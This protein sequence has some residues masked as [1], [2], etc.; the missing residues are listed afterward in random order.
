[1]PTPPTTPSPRRDLASPD[2]LAATAQVFQALAHPARLLMVQAL[3]EGE[4]CVGDLRQLVGSDISTVSRHLSV[5]KQ[6][7]IVG[8]EKRG[9]QVFYSLL[10]PCVVDMFGCIE[11]V[12]AA[13][14]ARLPQELA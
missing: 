2:H 3:R 4:C 13:R 14:A 12:L 6:A 1:M 10:V 9:N 8:A 7:G 11:S 5:M